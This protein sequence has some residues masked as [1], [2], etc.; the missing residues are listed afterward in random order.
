MKAFDLSEINHR[1]SLD[2]DD[3]ARWVATMAHDIYVRLIPGLLDKINDE[4]IDDDSLLQELGERLGI[5][6]R[7]SLIAAMKFIDARKELLGQ[8]ASDAAK[9]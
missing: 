4:K 7:M 5:T 3:V 1:G 2:D 9:A 6:A 8:L